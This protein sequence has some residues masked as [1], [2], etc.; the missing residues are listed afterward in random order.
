MSSLKL[1]LLGPPHLERDGVPLDLQTRRKNIALVAY[2]AVTRQHHTRETL[3]TLLWPELEPSRGRAGLRRNLSLLNKVLDG[4]WLVVDREL[5]GTDPDADLWLDVEQFRSLLSAWR[6]HGHPETDVCVDC[7]VALAQAVSLYRGDFL[8]GFSLSDSAGFDEWQFFQTDSLRRELASALERL[9]RGHSDR[10]AYESAIRYALR[11]LALDPLH[12]PVQRW[13]MLLYARAGQRAAAL[14]QYQECA[15]ILKEELGLAP[16][17]ETLSLYEQIR[18]RQIDVEPSSI[19]VAPPRHNL[20]AQ[21]TRFIGRQGSLA[22]IRERLQNPDCRLLTLVGPGGCGKTRLA[23]E[24]AGSLLDEFVHGVFFVPL[25]PLQSVEAILPTVAQA[26]GLSFRGATE[27][28]IE[29]EP[30]QQLLDYLRRKHILLILDNF[31][32]LLDGVALVTDILN[33]APGARVLATSRT[34]LNLQSEH[35]FPVTGMGLPDT[36]AEL[37]VTSAR[38]V[39][40]D[41]GLTTDNLADV[42]RICHLVGGMPLAILLAAAWVQMLSP[43][44]IV[45]QISRSID[46]LETD[47]RDLPERHRSMR[48]VFDHSW[49]LLDVR[50]RTVMQTLSIFRG[51]FTWK[52][53]QQVASVSLQGLR[54]LVDKSWLQRAPMDRFEMHELV[55]QYAAEKLAQT[56]SASQAAYDQHSA[57]YTSALQHW[58]TDLKGFQQQQALAEMDVEIENARVA[59]DWAVVQGQ[60]K[61]LDR[62]MDGLC[63]FHTRRSRY[64]EGAALC[65]AAAEN[66]Q[67]A[68]HNDALRVRARALAWQSAFQRELGRVELSSNLLQQSLDLV[69]ELELSGQH[70]RAEKAAIL[71]HLGEIAYASDYREAQGLFEESLELCRVS[72][73]RWRTAYV[74]RVLGSAALNLGDYGRA[75]RSYEESLAIRRALGDQ[76]GIAN[77]LQ[78]LS[79]VSLS[80]G[81]IEQG[82]RL[83]REGIALSE[84]IGDQAGIVKGLGN[85]GLLLH[86]SGRFAEAQALLEKSAAICTDLGFRVGLVYAQAHLGTTLGLIGKYEQSRALASK[87]LALAREIGHSW[88]MGWSLMLLGVS[89]LVEDAYTEA[90]R[91]IQESLSVYRE[92]GQQDSTG[93]ALVFSGIVALRL[94][95]V[96]V[97][98]QR[99]CEVLKLDTTIGRFGSSVTAVAAMALLLAEQGRLERAVELYATASRYPLISNSRWFKDIVGKHIATAAAT[100]SPQVVAAAQE[101]GRARDLN[102]TVAELL[103]ELTGSQAEQ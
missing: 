41:F 59:W 92:A 85:L 16:S 73:D 38:R 84:E 94:G 55:R 32:H 7:L 76:W 58:A 98:R 42:I 44:E 47:L 83:A 24:A 36:A 33:V 63:L 95:Q 21:S 27:G 51:G 3:V 66:L 12:E 97:A 69:E 25:A 5:V 75:K 35:L 96:S 29:V 52:A 67:M 26:V 82:E 72:G 4:E 61:Q 71:L 68:T 50:E 53:A 74:L 88:A 37:F 34:R 17:E 93:F 11:W 2:L 30:R 10:G 86:W 81:E 56:P 49:K 14:R 1:F 101:R 70:T 54:A 100:L 77:S 90:W 60:M 78:G 89:A 19:P 103:V 64:Q 48:A 80:L 57:H 18:T 46:F 22:E 9:V 28:E 79:R 99:L 15:R 62:A 45:A 23:L 87:C 40:P 102:A 39:R 20:P 13:L 91:F 65:R 31:E 8:A 43:A 6:D